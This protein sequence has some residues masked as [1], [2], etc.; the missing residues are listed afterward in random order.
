MGNQE[1]L[2]DD[3]VDFLSALKE[4]DE[5][6]NILN[7]IVA[8]NFNKYGQNDSNI[9]SELHYHLSRTFKV[10][11]SAFISYLANEKEFE[12]S[13]LNVNESSFRKPLETVNKLKRIYGPIINILLERD[14]NPFLINE[15]STSIGE[16]ESFHTMKIKRVDG[17]SLEGVFK[18][19]SL[20]SISTVLISS[21][22]QS[23]KKG[24]FNLNKRTIDN[25]L[26]QSENFNAFLKELVNSREN[27]E[28]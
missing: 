13:E 17:N 25:F 20:M 4:Y 18:P 7:S 16:K 11:S 12:L 21:L 1:S 26:T 19:E 6:H 14:N 5:Y 22:E 28:D 23:L 15:I 10:N 3:L 27:K 24:I 9:I 8:L 2:K